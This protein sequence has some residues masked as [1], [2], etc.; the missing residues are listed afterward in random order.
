MVNTL[1][2]KGYI[3]SVEYSREDRVFFGKIK[4]IDD[5]VTFESDRAEELEKVFQERVDDYLLTRKELEMPGN[6]NHKRTGKFI[7]MLDGEIG[8]CNIKK[9][10]HGK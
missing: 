4:M 5:L 3:G 7:G 1:E 9:L 10:L 6:D 2:Y 8:N